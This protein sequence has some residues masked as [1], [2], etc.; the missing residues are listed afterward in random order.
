MNEWTT[1]A[2]C[3]A[4]GIG[5]LTLWILLSDKSNRHDSEA[6]KIIKKKD[7][8]EKLCASKKD[9]IDAASERP[10]DQ[11]ED[12]EKT[13]SPEIIDDENI[14]TELL[15]PDVPSVRH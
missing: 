3:V 14:V 12:P 8:A 1:T 5:L 7:K 10:I 2:L 9:R 15:T 4:G 11:D 13:R 6:D